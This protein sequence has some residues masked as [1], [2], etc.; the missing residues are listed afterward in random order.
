MAW[1]RNDIF[2]VS[3]RNFIIYLF[4]FALFLMMCLR[5]IDFN[6]LWVT[7]LEFTKNPTLGDAP[8]A[9]E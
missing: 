2:F 3:D 4:G 9:Y 5:K 1:K 8:Y 7:P 6:I